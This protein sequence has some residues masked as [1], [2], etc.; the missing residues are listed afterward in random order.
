MTALTRCLGAAA[1]GVT[2]LVSLPGA[3]VAADTG[4]AASTCVPLSQVQR[5]IVQKAEV[6]VDALRDFVFVTRRVYALNMMEIAGSLDGWLERA[7]CT[8]MSV[9]EE[10]VRQNV[11]LAVAATP[12]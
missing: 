3:A 1:I 9:D 11:A 12:R 4:A 7:Q 8:R 2:V 5:R 10:A 6:S